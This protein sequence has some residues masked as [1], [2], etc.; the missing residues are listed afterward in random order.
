MFP[1]FP[2]SHFSI[3]KLPFSRNKKKEKKDISPL[4]CGF[5][6]PCWRTRKCSGNGA[7]SKWGRK[8][9]NAFFIFDAD[10]FKV[11]FHTAIFF[12]SLPVFL[13]FFSFLF[14]FLFL[15]LF[16]RSIFLLFFDRSLFNASFL[17]KLHINPITKSPL[18]RAVITR[19]EVNANAN[20]LLAPDTEITSDIPEII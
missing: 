8:S 13:F 19:V 17:I 14:L 12:H 16:P 9:F 4:K 7:R 15:Y 10:S 5:L 6:S 11:I 2:R 1:H 3:V 18:I 20:D